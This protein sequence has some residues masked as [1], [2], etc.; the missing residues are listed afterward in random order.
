MGEFVADFLPHGSG[1]PK[2]KM[3]RIRTVAARNPGE[4]F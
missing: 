4:P 2:A 3:V 1:L